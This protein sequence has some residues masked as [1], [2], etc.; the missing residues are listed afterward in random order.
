[1]PLVIPGPPALSDF[2]RAALL[3]RCRA[4]CPA[5]AGIYRLG[6]AFQTCGCDGPGFIPSNKT[7][8][9]LYLQRTRKEYLRCLQRYEKEES[10]LDSC[11]NLTLILTEN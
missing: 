7:E 2:R 3:E 11:R 8:Y 4:L 6:H 10:Y 9:R 1:M 5:I